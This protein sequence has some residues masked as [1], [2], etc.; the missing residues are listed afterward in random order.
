MTEQ[1]NNILHS[2]EYKYTDIGGKEAD[3]ISQGKGEEQEALVDKAKDN[4]Y[5]VRTSNLQ[6]TPL[7]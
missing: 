2:D 5:N 3:E 1:A 6:G 4:P 7:N